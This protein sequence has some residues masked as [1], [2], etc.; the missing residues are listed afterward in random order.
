MKRRIFFTENYG[1]LIYYEKNYGT[2]EKTIV[3]LLTIVNYSLILY[4]FYQGGCTVCDCENVLYN[5]LFILILKK[6]KAYCTS[7][8]WLKY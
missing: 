8:K 5:I 2:M 3:L 6:I 7:V 1:A 4:I